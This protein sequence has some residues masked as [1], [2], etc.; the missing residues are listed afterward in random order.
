MGVH[1]HDEF[2]RVDFRP[3]SKVEMVPPHHPAQEEMEAFAGP[4]EARRGEEMV[5]PSREGS[6]PIQGPRIKIA[7]AFDKTGE[8]FAGILLLLVIA[9]KE[10]GPQGAV[11]FQDLSEE[12]QE[13][14]QV[15]GGMKS[16]GKPAKPFQ[17]PMGIEVENG[18][19]GM[20]AERLEEGI[21]GW[22]EAFD[23]TVGEGGGKKSHGLDLCRHGVSVG[24]FQGGGVEV[25]VIVGGIE[26]IEI[27]LE[28]RST[29]RGLHPFFT[30]VLPGG[31]AAVS[32]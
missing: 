2:A 27:G 14:G 20:F 18:L 6:L 31:V 26:G 1:R 25:P 13:T 15:F 16:I 19:I 4:S 8:G 23:S 30:I 29:L 11:P 7:E 9:S 28:G 17:V 21:Q 24:E 10:K 22:G 12:P 5:H 32:P 3:E